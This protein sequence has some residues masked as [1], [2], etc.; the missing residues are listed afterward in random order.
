MYVKDRGSGD[1]W[2]AETVTT[3]SGPVSYNVRLSDGCVWKCH[4]DQL[5]KRYIDTAESDVVVDVLTG[6]SPPAVV[7]TS[8]PTDSDPPVPGDQ[9][10]TQEPRRYP[11]CI[12]QC[13]SYYHESVRS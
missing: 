3:V 11:E 2:L 9:Q 13:P 1:K 8:S 10:L 12:R 7:D 5:R 6:D 4:Q